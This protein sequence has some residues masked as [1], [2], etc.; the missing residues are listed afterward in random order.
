MALFLYECEFKLKSICWCVYVAALAP[1]PFTA[2]VTFKVSADA[3][4]GTQRKME[5]STLFMEAP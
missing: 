2:Q 5:I 3:K 4:K 1:S